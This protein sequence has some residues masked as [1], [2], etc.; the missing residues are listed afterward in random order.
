MNPRRD[1]IVIFL[2]SPDDLSVLN[3]IRYK[4]RLYC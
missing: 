2:E 4:S 3:I 1:A